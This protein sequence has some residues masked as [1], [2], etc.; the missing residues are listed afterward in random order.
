M[1]TKPKHITYSEALVKARHYCAYQERCHYEVE[2][3]LKSLGL[4][5]EF[6]PAVCV[7]LSDE[8]YLNEGRFVSAFVRGKFNQNGWG[9]LK[10][11]QGLKTKRISSKMIEIGLKEIDESNYYNTLVSILSNKKKIIR[12]KDQFELR[13]K[14]HRFGISRGFENNQVL[15]ALKEIL[16]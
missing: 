14:L 1:S 3:K 7:T 2:Q 16:I 8:G 9:R 15:N 6:I 10:I 5:H 4:H 11:M 13:S 12:S